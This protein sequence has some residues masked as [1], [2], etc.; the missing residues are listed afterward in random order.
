MNVEFHNGDAESLSAVGDGSIDVALVNGVFNLNPARE[1]IF[2]ELARV[3]RREGTLFAAE[4]ILRK[5]L[6]Q[7][8]ERSLEAWF[9]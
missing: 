5:P 4:I 3:V 8:T 1:A 9:A 2:S 6:P 7:E